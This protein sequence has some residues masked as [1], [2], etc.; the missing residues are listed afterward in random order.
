MFSDDPL[1]V[2]WWG[3]YLRSYNL[4]YKSY[5]WRLSHSDMHQEVSY[6]HY[7][8]GDNHLQPLHHLFPLSNDLSMPSNILLLDAVSLHDIRCAAS[9]R[10]LM[11]LKRDHCR[12]DIRTWS[13]EC[14]CRL[15]ARHL[16]NL[17]CVEL[18][19]ES[20]N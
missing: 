13:P 16:T 6:Q 11:Y 2:V 1:V 5:H 10:S 19:H 4:P 3:D 14:S 15:D 12:L 9:R 8:G 18:E 7:S 20:P 17:H